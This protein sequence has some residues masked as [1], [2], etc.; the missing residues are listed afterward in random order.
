M[1]NI[2]HDTKVDDTL[3]IIRRLFPAPE[4]NASCL[5]P[6]TMTHFASMIPAEKKQLTCQL[7]NLRFCSKFIMIG[8]Q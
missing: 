7:C 5:V 1:Y 2:N 6:E 4:R 3:T 8:L